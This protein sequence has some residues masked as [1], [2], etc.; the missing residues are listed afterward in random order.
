MKRF[1]CVLLVLCF[2]PVLALADRA[3]EFNVYASVFGMPE[4]DKGKV[5]SVNG[6]DIYKVGACAVIFKGENTVIVKGTGED[7]ILYSMCAI[8]SFEKSATAIRENAGEFLYYYLMIRAGIEFQ[9]VL[10]TVSGQPFI[11]LLDDGE[12][13]LSLGSED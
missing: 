11:I 9:E 8:M 3:D 6:F 1:V 5:S 12:Y 2:L 10:H 7:F 4:L 13:V